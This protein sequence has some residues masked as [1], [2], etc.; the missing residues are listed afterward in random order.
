MLE[1]WDAFVEEV[2]RERMKP[3]GRPASIPLRPFSEVFRLYNDGYG[4]R[5]F[6]RQLENAGVYTTRG[7][8]SRLILV[9]AT[10]RP[11]ENRISGMTVPA[12]SIWGFIIL[13]NEARDQI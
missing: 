11:F 5:K 7:S 8:V 10:K 12:A 1:I 6:V 2:G 3:T 4:C 9:N 13:S